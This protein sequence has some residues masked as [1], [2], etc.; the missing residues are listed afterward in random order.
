MGENRAGE[1]MSPRAAARLGWSACA[2][3]LVSGA[4]AFVLI[5]VHQSEPLD[6]WL[7]TSTQEL[8]VAT[9]AFVGYSV[10]GALLVSRHPRNPIGWLFCLA[11]LGAG[12]GG[13]ATE[14]AIEALIVDPGSLPAGEALAWLGSWPWILFVPVPATIGLLL[15]PTGHVV[16]PRW[17]LALWLA[18]AV[19]VALFLGFAFDK[20]ELEG[21]AID[22][23]VGFLPEGS[24]AVGGLLLPVIALALAS[25][26]V[27]YRRAHGDERQQLR[28]MA[29]AAALFLVAIPLE[30]V[31][32]ALT[33]SWAGWPTLGASAAI[34]FA[35]GVAVLKYRLY[36]LDLVVNRTLVYGALTA[37]VVAGYVGLVAGL[38]ELLDST[39]I[40]VSLI[41]TAVVAVAIQPLR[42]LIQARID[43]LMYGDR[44]DPYRALSRLG[45]RLGQALD[46]DAV[47]PAIV[48]AVADGLRVPYVAI[49]LQEG[50]AHRIAAR[51]GEPRGGE[52]VRL[53]LEYRGEVVGRLVAAPRAGSDVLNP[54]DLRLLADLA[55]QAGVAAHAVRL[56]QDLRRSRE[57]LVAAREE[58]RRRL[59]RDLHD[60]LG[61]ALAGIALEIESARGLV[62]DDPEAAQQ[63]LERLRGE[64][65]E[66]IA[67]IRRIAYDL[68]P[69]TLD[70]LGL[71]AAVREQ[72]ARLG[73][74]AGGGGTNGLL[75]S[76]ETPET[77][78][79]LPAAVEVA[80]Y[81]IA[82]E[83]LT[84]V[85]RH[86]GASSCTVRISVNGEL[87]LEVRDDGAGVG[88]EAARG[89]GL[90]SMRERAEELGGS[91]SVHSDAGGRGTV[92][93][94]RLPVEE[95]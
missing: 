36:D 23:P 18:I 48:E 38:G 63:L 26:I 68:R 78:P 25:L 95:G 24:E 73:V 89:I 53:P 32:S 6:D 3:S 67:D 49:E 22:N 39:G 5:L 77:L 52:L 70:E 62:A 10:F 72:A 69:P 90:T 20:G 66:A 92:V 41:A 75:V 80:A 56:T 11:G 34:V 13:V 82:L 84:N 40:G 43:R 59:R 14:Y 93:A 85:S 60:G 83:A 65:Q 15:F 47:L 29:A 4:V 21:F 35:A 64:V 1:G 74:P 87:E 88:P 79:P 27:R 45:Q 37:L 8:V 12:I 17:R 71:V 31:L 61:P 57:R 30:I 7:D 55:H 33:D 91:L 28:W 51:H 2:V 54:A 58:E 94:A 81:R 46:P 19:N 9:L 50:G 42:S 16:S 76:V 44:D 86:A